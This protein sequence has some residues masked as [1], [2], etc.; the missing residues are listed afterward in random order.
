MKTKTVLCGLLF[1]LMSVGMRAAD[2]KTGINLYESG[3]CGAAKVFFLTNLKTLQDPNIQAEAYYYLGECYS[4]MGPMDSARVCYE[5]GIVLQPENPYNQVGLGKLKL[6]SDANGAEVLL[7]EALGAKG[8][9]KDVGLQLAV[10]RAYLFAGDRTKA[11]EYVNRAKEYDAKS[12]RPYLV[13]GDILVDEGKV[14]D[15]CAKYEMATYFSPDCVGAYLKQAQYYMSTNR[16]LSLEKLNKALELA[17]DFCGTYCSLGE[18]HEMAGDSKAAV[19]N[20]SKFIHAGFYGTEH[21]LR[22][23]GIL[24]YNKQYDEMLPVLQTV[25]NKKSDNLVAKRLY[26]Y[27]LSKQ[28]DTEKCMEAIKHF[29]E[30]TPPESCIYQDYICYAEQ[31]LANKLYDP[32]VVYYKKALQADSKKQELYKDIA[33]VFEKNRQLDSAVVYYE[34]YMGVFKEPAAADVLV[35]GKCYYNLAS[36]D[37]VAVQQAIELQKADTLFGTLS[38][39]VPNSYVSYFWRAR[40]KSMLDPETTQGLAKPYYE[41]VIEIGLKEP[42]RF[43]RELVEGYKYLG[44]YHYV[45]ADA[46]TS[47]N[48]GNPDPAKQ[49]YGEA[50]AFFSK[51]LEINP[52]DEIALKALESIKL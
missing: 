5:K 25:M 19:E 45:L 44:Y 1:L 40:V 20:Y 21:L 27:C 13:E 3:M 26:A 35:L 42:D 17:P 50:K 16:A 36:Q 4:I 29:I 39:L 32:C 28:K 2:N 23:A 18:L 10:A 6:K 47:K 9:K 52:K 11:M 30:T 15:A 7:K 14:G 24:Y 33:G 49:E 37:T 46:I 31:L 8:F 34:Q 41:K 12:G 22:Y 38:T 43:K 48:N 51:V